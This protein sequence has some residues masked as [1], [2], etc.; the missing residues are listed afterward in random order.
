MF[1]EVDPFAEVKTR[2]NKFLFA[3]QLLV[4]VVKL[5][6]F[7]LLF[8]FA[9]IQYII[10]TIMPINLLKNIVARAYSVT[11]VRLLLWTLGEKNVPIV[12]TP[13]CE[14]YFENEEKPHPVAGD[15]IISNSISY[16]SLFWYQVQYSPIFVIPLTNS[17]TV[18]MHNMFALF[19][20]IIAGKSVQSGQKTTMEKAIKR[21]RALGVP[22]VVFPESATTNGKSLIKFYNFCGDKEL[23]GVHFHI[24]GISHKVR[25]ISP[26]CTGKNPS[27]HLVMMLGRFS[28]SMKVYTALPQDIP[29]FSENFVVDSRALLGK[30][31]RVPLVNVSCAEKKRK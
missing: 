19:M 2:K 20:Y 24:F 26:F 5:P 17:G 21:A 30:I 14:N 8:S 29:Q 27:L 10:S 6:L 12:P 13:L 23:G 3:L 7:I 22:V 4:G 25:L 15:V 9:F 31:L 11:I 28:S 18:V 16:I 1:R